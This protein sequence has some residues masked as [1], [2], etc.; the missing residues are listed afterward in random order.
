[1]SQTTAEYQVTGMTCDHCVRAVTQ[2]VGAIAGVDDVAVDLATGRVTVRSSRPL[3]AE[4][5]AAAI[6]EAGYQLTH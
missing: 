4:E 2:E 3:G 5:M 6:D 1:M